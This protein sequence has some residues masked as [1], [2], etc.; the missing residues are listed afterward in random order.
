MLRTCCVNGNILRNVQK[1]GYV[2]NGWMV[3][4]G[5]TR[6]LIKKIRISNEIF[7]AEKCLFICFPIIQT[8]TFI[9]KIRDFEFRISDFKRNIFGWKVS[10]HMKSYGSNQDFTKRNINPTNECFI[11]L[12]VYSVQILNITS[13]GIILYIIPRENGRVEFFDHNR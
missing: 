4:D 10:F 7:S 3:V 12:S 2:R 13:R 8:G 1:W 11:S 6:T 5:W 9:I